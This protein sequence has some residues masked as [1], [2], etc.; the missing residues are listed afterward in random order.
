MQ[1]STAYVP[2]DVFV[3]SDRGDLPLPRV[4]IAPQRYIQGRG[5]LRGIGRYLSLTK[6]KRVALL[7]SERGSRSEGETL[8]DGLHAAGIECVACVFGG[9]CS[10]EE[11]TRHVDALANERI[12]CVIAAGGGK[13]ID[14][15]KAVAF[16][17]GTPVVIA[18]TLASNDAPVLGAVDPLLAGRRLDGG[19]VLPAEPRHRRRRHR[20]RRG[21][22]GTLPRRRHGRRHGHLVRGPRLPAEP[23]RDDDRRRAAHD[24]VRAPSARS[25]R[26]RCSGRGSPRPRPWRRSTVNDS[27]EAIVEANTLLS[28]LGFESG[29]VAAAHGVAQSYTAIPTVHANYLHG[30]MVAMGTLAQ[31]MMEARPDEAARVAEFFAAV[32]LPVH[33]GQLSLDAG[34]SR[35]LDVVVEGT[36]AFPAIGNMPQAGHRAGGAVGD[37]RRASRSGVSVAEKVGDAAYRRLH[38]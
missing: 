17:L 1:I 5:V 29:G 2:Y 21:R 33:L 38:A 7:M 32:G 30:E 8:R 10:L 34:D 9:E 13:C 4:F 35:A 31:L 25:A 24:R 27:L 37:S 23:G 36:L 18:P 19:R 28:G 16:R 11:I 20:H 26:R 6:A 14:A 3:S 22:A 12:D 15:G